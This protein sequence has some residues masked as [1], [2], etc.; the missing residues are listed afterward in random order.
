M[1]VFVL[2]GFAA[3]VS[4]VQSDIAALD[5]QVHTLDN[6]IKANFD[7]FTTLDLGTKLRE[8]FRFRTEALKLI[9]VFDKGTADIK[10]LPV[11]V[12]EIDAQSF[13]TPFKEMEP[14]LTDN[15][16]SIIMMIDDPLLSNVAIRAL[17]KR[18]LNNLHTSKNAFINALI[19][20]A[21]ASLVPDMTTLM[22]R[23]DVGFQAVLAA[24]S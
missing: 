17:A 14:L 11:P 8:I 20:S 13:I 15:F 10:T 24:H 1:T 3:T 23:I 5:S 18:D 19:A 9:T 21:P 4:D 22:D 6:L 2:S 12:S 16:N 7:T